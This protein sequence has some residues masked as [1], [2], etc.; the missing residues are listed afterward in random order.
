MLDTT[1]P[2]PTTAGGDDA[3]ADL[4][5]RWLELGEIERRAFLA[6][7]EEV[8]QSSALIEQSTLDL[9]ARFRELAAAA[10]AQTGRVRRVAALA[11]AVELPGER[12]PM[13]E[14]VRV[15]E[16][17]LDRAIAALGE[18]AAQAGAMVQALDG[19]AAEVAGAEHCVSRIEAINKQARFVALN[20]SIEAQRAEGSGGTFKVIAQELRDLAQETDKTSRLVRE[21]IMA[22]TRGVAAAHRDLQAIATA[23]RSAAAATRARLNQVLAALVAQNREVTAVV[24]E[25]AGASAEIGATIARLVTG[26]QFQ[27]RTT[28]H[29]THVI[30]A[31]GAL[32]EATEALQGETRRTLPGD[33]PQGAPDPALLARMLERQTLSAVR[34]R[35]LARL[36]D[37]R[38][39]VPEAAP[40]SGGDIELF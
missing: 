12:L 19:V 26:A 18:V 30:E 37:D 36:L 24:A 22:V 39:T 9:S 4:L 11:E 14:A 3:L 1:L 38:A 17:A 34:Q 20:A 31:L 35:F 27:D 33:L 21:R 23:D 29:L 5:R 40:D 10:E 6:M 7:A 28:Q 8:S 16:L 25:A 13:S 32:G 2:V 15:V